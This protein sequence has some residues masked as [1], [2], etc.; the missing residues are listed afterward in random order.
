[1]EEQNA[2]SVYLYG[3]PGSG[4]STLA[5]NNFK[6]EI[7]YFHLPN[8][9]PEITPTERPEIVIERF[10]EQLIEKIGISPKDSC[11]FTRPSAKLLTIL[12]N[13]ENKTFI[14]D[15]IDGALKKDNDAHC[16]TQFFKNILNENVSLVLVSS[17]NEKNIQKMCGA[18]KV[19][20]VPVFSRPKY[21]ISHGVF[22]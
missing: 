8:H 18:D 2:Q 13:Q 15:T 1:M 16:L 22:R 7:A 5:R 14:L 4:K 6:E 17:H 21:S 19:V 12:R 9:L 11:A 10:A 3:N 20:S